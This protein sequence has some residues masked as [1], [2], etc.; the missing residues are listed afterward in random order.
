[1]P[2]S[3]A[4]EE[5]ARFI[6]QQVFQELKVAWAGPEAEFDSDRYKARVQGGDLKGQL[7]YISA[8][9]LEDRNVSADNIKER[10][11]TEIKGQLARIRK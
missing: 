2:L 10:L 7:F 11:L 8:N 1:M 5:K 3:K 6:F 9:N 4:N